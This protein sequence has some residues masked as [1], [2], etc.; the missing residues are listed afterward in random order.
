MEK[1]SICKALLGRAEELEEVAHLRIRLQ[2]QSRLPQ[3]DGMVSEVG[4]VDGTG[5][6]AGG[7]SAPSPPG[8][9]RL[10]SKKVRAQSASSIDREPGRLP[11]F[12]H[13]TTRHGR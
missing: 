3:W 13:R 4:E 11:Q 1:V 10:P 9:A 6:G 2:P 12:P 5:R 7:E 8:L